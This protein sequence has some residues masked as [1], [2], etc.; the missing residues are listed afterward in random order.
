MLP[1]PFRQIAPGL[2]RTVW[3][4]STHDVPAYKRLV[5]EKLIAEFHPRAQAQI[6]R[7]MTTAN[8]DV[9]GAP[10]FSPYHRSLTTP[11]PL[12]FP[13]RLGRRLLLFD[14]FQRPLFV[15]QLPFT[16]VAEGC[17]LQNQPFRFFRREGRVNCK[18]F[19]GEVCYL[20]CG[21]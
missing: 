15:D 21:H 4:C 10:R 8:C 14:Q 11:I 19:T 6:R 17:A 18:Q 20:G 3:L 16:V 2:S 13:T 5:L 7:V 1:T 12:R 9:L